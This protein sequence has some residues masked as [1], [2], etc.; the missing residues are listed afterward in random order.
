MAAPTRTEVIKAAEL[1][2][3]AASAAGLSVGGVNV[4]AGPAKPKGP[5]AQFWAN[6]GY[7]VAG[8]PDPVTGEAVDHFVSLPFGMPLDNMEPAKVTGTGEFA[9]LQQN[10]N[11][12]YAD[13][14]EAVKAM[15]PGSTQI[16]NLQ[17]QVRRVAAPV[18]QTAVAGSPLARTVKLF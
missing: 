6:I 18:A 12:L 7:T 17:V 11:Q 4:N 2:A 10:K 3:Q 9:D 5:P 1:K 15:A 16:S 14:M 13:L 8:V